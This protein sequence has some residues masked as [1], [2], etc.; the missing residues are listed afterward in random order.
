MARELLMLS[1]NTEYTK[2]TLD[3]E[4]AVLATLA[5]ITLA[6]AVDLVGL[7]MNLKGTSIDTVTTITLA[8]ELLRLSH[9]EA[10]WEDQFMAQPTSARAT[11]TL[12]MALEVTCNGQF[13][14]VAGDRLNRKS[15]MVIS[16][17]EPTEEDSSMEAVEATPALAN[18]AFGIIKIFLNLSTS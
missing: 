15:I 17:L 12:A 18:A 16:A 9:I 14:T 5:S 3:M 10:L 4:T 8:R 11:T 13:T 1:R 6:M 7:I 2:E